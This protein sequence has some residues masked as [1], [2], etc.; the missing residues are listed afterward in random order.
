MK[1]TGFVVPESKRDRFITM[2]APADMFDPMEPGL[3][4]ADDPHTG[5]YT[6]DR[7]FLSGGGGLVSTVQDY[8][9]FLTM[10]VRCGDFQGQQILQPGTIEAMRSN[11]LSAGIGVSFP[12]WDMPGTVFGLGLALKEHPAD[13]EPATAKAEYHW[14]GIGGTHTWIA[15]EANLVGMCMTQ[16]MPGFWH[17]FSH[18]FKRLAYSLSN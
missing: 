9:N 3:T 14:G 6:K 7:N 4:L 18:D 10:L 13:D 12:M 16:L 8:L 17:P 2:Y 15:P 5:L 11:Q 1:D